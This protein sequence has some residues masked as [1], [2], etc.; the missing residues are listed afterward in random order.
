MK[1]GRGGKCSVQWASGGSG[2]VRVGDADFAFDALAAQGIANGMSDA[3]HLA[4]PAPVR[5]ERAAHRR[6]SHLR[7]LTDALRRCRFADEPAWRAYAD[8]LGPG[9]PATAA[10]APSAHQMRTLSSGAM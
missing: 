5:S 4:E 6:A 3:L 10:A 9:L 1:P 8:W 2:A 7:N